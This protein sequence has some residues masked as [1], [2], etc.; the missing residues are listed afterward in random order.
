MDERTG[1][2]LLCAFALFAPIFAGA[3]DAPRRWEVS[4]AVSFYSPDFSRAI[5]A[6]S[7]QAV[8][9]L[10]R[11]WWVGAGGFFARVAQDEPTASPVDG[12]RWWAAEALLYWNMAG[13]LGEPGD[14]MPIDLFTSAG[15]AY[16]NVDGEST[17]AGMIG[18]GMVIHFP[19]APWVAARFDLKN[20][21]YRTDNPRGSDFTSDL[22]LLIGPSFLF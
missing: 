3:Q 11:T 19:A 14:G 10:D 1:R 12:A 17:M 5:V 4:P 9:R 13:W 16:F 8:F 7:L 22:T 18:G 6:P 20:Y 15:P 21:M 2:K